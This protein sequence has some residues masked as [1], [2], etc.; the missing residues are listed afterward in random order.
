MG[1]DLQLKRGNTVKNAAYTGKIAEITVDT[2]KHTVVVH[3]GATAGGF[4]LA[5]A[6]QLSEANLLRADKYLAS[7][8]LAN[9][10]YTS[11]NLTKIQYNNAIDV[12]YEVLNYTSGSLTSINHYVDSTLAGTSTLSYTDGAL[13]SVIFVEA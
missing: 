3:D 10:I 4:P 11:G 12:D 7:Q 1:K 5:T 6:V 8:D 13:T 2:D 9:M